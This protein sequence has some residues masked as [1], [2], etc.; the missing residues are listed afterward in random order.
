MKTSF[1]ISVNTTV[2]ERF[3]ILL[4]LNRSCRK[5]NVAVQ[6]EVEDYFSKSLFCRIQQRLL[7]GLYRKEIY[8]KKINIERQIIPFTI[9][10]FREMQMV[11]H[12]G[13]TVQQGGQ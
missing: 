1:F 10:L 11:A 3:V 6:L 7:W 9:L 13:F 4:V 8:R 5:E 12:R 2:P